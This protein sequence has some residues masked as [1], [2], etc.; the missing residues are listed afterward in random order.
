MRKPIYRSVSSICKEARGVININKG[1]YMCKVTRK[2]ITSPFAFAPARDTLSGAI[3][4]TISG[5]VVLARE[6]SQITHIDI[7][8]YY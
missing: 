6:L 5:P 8:N 2:D 7:K 4:A 1:R 3:E